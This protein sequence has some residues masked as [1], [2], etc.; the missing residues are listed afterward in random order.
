M[1]LSL[2]VSTVWKIHSQ[3][4]F[5]NELKN[6]S[7]MLNPSSSPSHQQFEVS[8]AGKTVFYTKPCGFGGCSSEVFSLNK[9][10]FD[11]RYFCNEHRIYMQRMCRLRNIRSNTPLGGIGE[12]PGYVTKPLSIQEFSM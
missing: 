8:H 6:K 2:N 12:K 9:A 7:T 10:V 4:T 3:K 11:R 1:S 5:L